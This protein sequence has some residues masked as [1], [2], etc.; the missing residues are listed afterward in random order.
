METDEEWPP[1]V[2]RVNYPSFFDSDSPRP[3]ARRCGSCSDSVEFYRDVSTER[4]TKMQRAS[5]EVS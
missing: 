2:L 1:I 5:H 4:G 3:R